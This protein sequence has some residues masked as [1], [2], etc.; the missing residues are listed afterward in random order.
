M[1]SGIPRKPQKHFRMEK[2]P[3]PPVLF[4]SVYLTNLQAVRV[5]LLCHFG[6]ETA[7]C[8]IVLIPNT[9]DWG[10]YES[11]MNFVCC[12]TCISA[13]KAAVLVGFFGAGSQRAEL[14]WPNWRI[15]V[16]TRKL[17]PLHKYEQ[18]MKKVCNKGFS[19]LISSIHFLLSCDLCCI[20][21]KSSV[22]QGVVYETLHSECLPT[23][24]IQLRK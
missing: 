9:R 8:D 18:A 17:W 24:W 2:P 6:L 15:N 21:L 5:S 1:I 10:H 20:S 23:H 13:D 16:A 7:V 12:C 22:I 11:T 4:H 14:P 3:S 19:G